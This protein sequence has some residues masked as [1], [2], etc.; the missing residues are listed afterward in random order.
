MFEDFAGGIF[1]DLTLIPLEGFPQMTYRV[2][3]KKGKVCKIDIVQE[4]QIMLK[5]FLYRLFTIELY[6]FKENENL[7]AIH[8]ESSIYKTHKI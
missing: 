4:L 1:C 5:T 7:K 3:H 8:L 2:C 6:I